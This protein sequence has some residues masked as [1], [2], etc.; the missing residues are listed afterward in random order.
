MSTT[1]F[2]DF[3]ALSSA[4]WK[5]QIQYELKG[6]D[7]ADLIWESPEG[8][9]VKPFYHRDADTDQLIPGTASKFA[10]CQEIF[11][12]DLEK[13][14]K[15]AASSLQ[16]GAEEIRFILPTPVD[17]SILLQNIPSEVT[18]FLQPLFADPQYVKKYADFLSPPK[19]VLLFDPIH[20]LVAD[21]NWYAGGDNFK[22][23]CEM[24]IKD[25]PTLS[26]DGRIY[27]NAGANIVQQLAYA[28]AHA[29]EYLHQIT[30]Y[31]EKII[32]QM[33]VG[34]NYF[35]EIAKLRA[36]RIAF[37][38]ISQVFGHSGAM[39][40]VAQP[41]RR[42]KTLYDYNVNMLRTTTECMSA[43][44]GGADTVQN[45]PY[46]ALY[47]KSNEFG[48][49]IARNQLLILKNES[50]FDETRNPA[51]GSYYIESL[52]KQLAEKALA[53]F[54]E[55]EASGGFLKQ[56]REGT[57]QRKIVAAADREQSLFDEGKIILVGTN[58]YPN[59]ADR[60]AND[61]ELYPFGKVKHRKTLIV[62]LAEVRL[63]EKHEQ[64]RLNAENA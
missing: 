35:F 4:Q 3:A 33:A 34:S 11:V 6:G 53:L 29:S 41:S 54:K 39:H 7:Y 18:V 36:L 31:R 2:K 1:L 38:S 24:L 49:R 23:A 5:Q 59:K 40:I 64:E 12:H 14:A 25:V 10:V 30:D 50:Y 45:L 19:C 48:E 32:F 60:M 51:D 56:L 21:G 43:I 55:I 37:A 46:D 15:R 16:R 28:L 62:P 17:L 27:Q 26:I 57:I 42:N 61:L 13:S 47:H 52:T 8:I 58:K 22:M 20:H 63:A 9:K 44:L